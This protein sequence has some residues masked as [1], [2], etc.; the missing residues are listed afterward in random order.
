MACIASFHLVRETPWKAPV[1]MARLGTD[2][3]R[4]ARTNGLVFWRLLGT[5]RGDHTGAG[6]DARRTAMFAVW[7]DEAALDTFLRS[8][9]IARRWT[10]SDES[11]HV[12]LRTL[13][14]HGRW[15]G[16][17]PLAGLEPGRDEGPVA[18]LTRATVRMGAWRAF[19]RAAGAVDEELHR[20]P[21]LID[22]VGIGEAPV[23]RLSTFSLWE[24]VGDARA[25][26][27]AMPRHTEVIQRTRADRWYRE[28][29]FAR[30]DPY[31]AAGT[32]GGRNP[33]SGRSLE[34]DE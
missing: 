28:E 7:S 19:A 17:D 30:F 26:A 32:W 5:G 9:R 14:G 29:L 25:F 23:A 3:G 6:I 4:L 10:E 13:G 12:R 15:R 22:V 2:R 16:V 11:W 34:A 27:Y 24:T 21:G 18:I 8:S 31:G 33:L 1:A 20:A